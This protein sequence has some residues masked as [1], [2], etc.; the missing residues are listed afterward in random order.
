[1]ISRREWIQAGLAG[2]GAL[3]VPALYGKERIGRSRISAISDEIATSPDEAIAFTKKYGLQWLELRSVPGNKASNYFYMDPEELKPHAR[4]FS[5]NGIRISYL[6]TFLLKFGL[7]GTEPVLRKPETPE[8]REQRQSREKAMFERRMDDLRKCI[9]SAH[10]LGAVNV[11]VFTFL[12]VTD[13]LALCLA[14]RKSWNR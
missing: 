14:L 9:V 5:D 3:G 13:P 1:M 2:T 7:P 10:I 11:R 12:R 4:Q 8:A 6:D